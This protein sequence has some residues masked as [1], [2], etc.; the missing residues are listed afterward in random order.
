MKEEV[1]PAD[2]KTSAFCLLTFSLDFW[3]PEG[4]EAGHWC[5]VVSFGCAQRTP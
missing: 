2:F 3:H 4:D 5:E 1:Q